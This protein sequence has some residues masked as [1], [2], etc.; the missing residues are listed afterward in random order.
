MYESGYAFDNRSRDQAKL[1][2]EEG[3]RAHERKYRDHLHDQIVLSSIDSLIKMHLNTDYIIQTA[4]EL[5]DKYIAE[6]KLRTNI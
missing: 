2:Y 3:A 6:R 1:F 4:F 5:A